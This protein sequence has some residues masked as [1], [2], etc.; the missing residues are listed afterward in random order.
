M[1]YE[2]LD[3]LT[4]AYGFFNTMRMASYAPQ[5]LLVAR[6]RSGAKNISLTSWMVWTAANITTAVYAWNKLADIP[7]M[8]INSFNAC[9]CVTMVALLVHKR[10]AAGSR[11]ARRLGGALPVT[12][13]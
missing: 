1:I 8:M 2:N 10:S 3:F 7:L 5:I 4:L 12:A 6:D 11:Q 13:E 9:C